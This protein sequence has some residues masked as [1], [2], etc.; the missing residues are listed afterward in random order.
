MR[1]LYA[2]EETWKTSIAK[3]SAPD[4]SLNELTVAIPFDSLTEWN[5][6]RA[7][8]QQTYG[9]SQV[10]IDSLSARGGIVK[11]RYDGTI[12]DLTR[13]L[14]DNGLLLSEVSGTWVI[15]PDY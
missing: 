9:V 12:E 2:M 1:F 11:V 7:R 10:E 14:E 15:Q 3:V 5:S 13:S 8:I 6:L 4:S